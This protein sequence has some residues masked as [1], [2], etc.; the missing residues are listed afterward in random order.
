MIDEDEREELRELV[1]WQNRRRILHSYAPDCRDPGH[2]GC[3]KC[4]DEGDEE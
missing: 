4:M 2:R 1:W 3:E